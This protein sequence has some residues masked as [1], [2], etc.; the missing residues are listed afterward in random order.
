MKAK[1][2][3]GEVGAKLTGMAEGFVSETQSKLTSI[4]D[5]VSNSVNRANE[6]ISG[7]KVTLAVLKA[8]IDDKLSSLSSSVAS[9]SPAYLELKSRYEVAREKYNLNFPKIGKVMS[10]F[11]RNMIKGNPGLNKKYLDQMKELVEIRKNNK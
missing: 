8:D 6:Y 11:I 5:S 4:R 1:A 7:G 3:F 10:F 2:E 9:K